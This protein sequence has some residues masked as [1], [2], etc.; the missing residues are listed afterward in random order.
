M[1]TQPIKSDSRWTVTREFHGRENPGF[2]VRFCGEWVGV[3]STYPAAVVLAVGSKARRDGALVIT[4][5][6]A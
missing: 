1:N 5:T 4:E 3:R 2:V 6:P